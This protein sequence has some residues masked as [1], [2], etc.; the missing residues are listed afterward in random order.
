MPGRASRQSIAPRV[1]W[2]HELRP[3]LGRRTEGSIVEC[4]KVFPHGA[5]GCRWVAF[6]APLAARNRTL[7]V[8]IGHDQ[9]GV[10]RKSLGA[11]KIRRN[12][13]LDDALEHTSENVTVA[14]P[15][16]ARPRED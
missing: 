15:L 4:G 1:G 16:V 8:G 7:L 14:E 3:D 2:R 11:D 6:R 10:D 13:G 5:A 12:A 9:A